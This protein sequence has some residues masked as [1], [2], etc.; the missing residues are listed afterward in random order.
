MRYIP[1]VMSLFFLLIGLQLHAQMRDKTIFHYKD[2]S[3]FIGTVLKENSQSAQVRITTS[4]TI[5]ISKPLIKKLYRN[6]LFFPNGKYH[7]TK[8][9]FGSVSHAFGGNSRNGSY[10]MQVLLGYHH[11]ESLD[12]GIGIGYNANTTRII[13]IWSNPHFF[14]TFLYARYYPWADKKVRPFVSMSLGAGFA[15][16][17][18]RGNDF[19]DGLY[20]QPAIGLK[21]PTKKPGSCTLSIGQ[22]LQRTTGSLSET[23]FLGNTSSSAFKMFLNRTMLTFTTE[24]R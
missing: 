9:I 13:G 8:G 21:F 3:V 5:N 12:Y 6:L 17:T 2:G 11:N 19:S 4:D 7:F 16:P 10:Q 18:W 22:M 15:I 14:H 23:D 20:M 1:Q 24:F